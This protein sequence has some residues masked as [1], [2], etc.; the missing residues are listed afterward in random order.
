M[1]NW[2]VRENRYKYPWEDPASYRHA[3]QPPLAEGEDRLVVPRYEMESYLRT[4]TKEWVRSQE[5]RGSRAR[6]YAL[7]PEEKPGPSFYEGWERGLEW[8]IE[9][10]KE[11]TVKIWDE[12]L[13][14]TR[15]R[16]LFPNIHLGR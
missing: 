12:N 15:T 16:E 1:N 14:E 9:Q 3:E 13:G 2:S 7:H 5:A 4:R 8:V 10:M 11:L 6:Y